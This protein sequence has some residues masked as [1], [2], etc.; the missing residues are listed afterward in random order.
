MH[1]DVIVYILAY[2]H[3]ILPT[4]CVLVLQIETKFEKIG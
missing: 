2:E 3:T 4:E 1:R